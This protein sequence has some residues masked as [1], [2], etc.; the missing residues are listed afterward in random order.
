MFPRHQRKRT[1][2]IFPLGK[3]KS[4]SDSGSSDSPIQ[5]RSK[6]KC[7]VDTVGYETAQQTSHLRAFVHQSSGPTKLRV[8][9]ET[10][11]LAHK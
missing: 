10:L 9:T 3:A 8:G 4:T 1:S 6:C 5:C 11:R 2:D 7:F